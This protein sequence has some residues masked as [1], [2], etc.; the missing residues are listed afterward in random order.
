MTDDSELLRQYAVQRSEAAFAQLV[1]RHLPLVYSAAVRRLGGDMHLASD[2]TQIVFAT[3]AREAASLSRHPVLTGWLYTTTRHAAIDVMRSEQ[4]RRIREQHAYAMQ[5]TSTAPEASVDWG[6]LRPVIDDALDELPAREREL[7]L[8]RFFQT[9]PFAEIGRALGVS[10]EAARKRVERTLDALRD[11][12]ARR[13]ITSTSAALAALLAAETTVAAPTGLAATVIGAAAATH[14]GLAAGILFM[15]FTKLQAAA[16]AA[17]LVGASGALLWQHRTI[18][19]LRSELTAVQARADRFAVENQMLTKP[20]PAEKA[21]VAQTPAPSTASQPD[22]ANPNTSAESAANRA[23]SVD[24]LVASVVSRAAI[25]RNAQQLTKLHQRYDGFLKQRGLTPAQI[26]RWIE[27]MME[28]DNIRLD[29]RDTMKELG[30]PASQAFEELRAK[31]T[32]PL[33]NEM[34][35]MLGADGFAAFN[36]YESMSYYRGFVEPLAPKLA[37][38]NEPL[39]AEQSDRLA[40]VIHA[41]DHPRHDNPTDLGSTSHI[42][43]SAVTEEA[44]GFLTPTQLTVLQDFAVHRREK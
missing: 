40:R 21:A 32:Q 36:E 5:E 41:N 22:A 2:V 28:K 33:W 18:A 26:D 10:E 14:H 1:D 19:A 20:R 42:D 17:V 31:A 9:R 11:R 15:S 35:E 34:R 6:K 24:N 7:V 3:L 4:R 29:L 30:V 12:L 43:W 13:G 25:P 44:R 37:V 8:L 39:S 27:V 16:L 38:K 23:P